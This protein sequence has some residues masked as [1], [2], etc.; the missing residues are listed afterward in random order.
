[1][2]RGPSDLQCAIF[3]RYEN[4]TS[5]A[6]LSAKH[7]INESTLRRSFRRWSREIP[8]R[9]PLHPL[10]V[11][12]VP[13]G[14]G[15]PC[16]F[17]LKEESV[18][19]DAVEHFA[20]NNTPLTKQDLGDLVQQFVAMLPSKRRNEIHF[21]NDRP[22]DQW[23][24]SFSNRH[25]L[26]CRNAQCIENKRVEAMSAANVAEHIA[27]VQAACK[28]Y[29]IKDGSRVFNMDQSGIS[30]AKM[31][32][33]SLRKAVTPENIKPVQI[34]VRTKGN[35]ERVTIMPVVSASG[36]TYTPVIVFPGKQ[37][38]FR[39]VR[40]TLQT[41]HNFLPPCYFY[42]REVPGVDSDII[43]DWAKK[44]VRE[45]AHLRSKSEYLLLVI[46]AFA[47]HVQFRT[48]N[49]FKENRVVVL[50]MP[51][52]SS[53]RLQPLDVSVFSAYKSYMQREIHKYSR[54]KK[55]LDVFDVSICI[56]DAYS[57]S[58]T[59]GNIVSGFRKSGIWDESILG[60]NIALLK[61]YITNHVEGNIN[62]HPNLNSLLRA[63]ENKDR[64]V[65]RDADVEDQGTIRIKTTRGCNLTS[66]VVLEALQ[67]REK[68]KGDA[69]MLK[70]KREEERLL[71]LDY[72]EKATDI[73]HLVEIA[74]ERAK[75]Q[76]LLKE[77]RAERRWQHKIRVKAR[78][79][80]CYGSSQGPFVDHNS[81]SDQ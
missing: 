81:D 61:A 15:R 76:R 12:C 17:T 18:I 78:L 54:S 26:S 13:V 72:K 51:A 10:D 14:P 31:C 57:A 49:Y 28:R 34:A 38:Q 68:K 69:F 20:V 36:Q 48:L 29:N 74:S 52:H 9:Q 67:K 33:R 47:G 25:N 11:N 56:R 71:R 24:K 37:A 30:F 62:G 45:T 53:H 4:Q 42:Q 1:M 80:D 58:H 40:G 50:A 44:F 64:T 41:V 65:L 73:D 7:N 55:V 39:R 35:L 3:D 59:T 16:A 79:S 63:F 75:R 6:V 77:S 23:I 22:S 43:F 60:P 27:R 8:E 19:K 32:G 21:R 5:W 70:R 2:K 46:D 66:D